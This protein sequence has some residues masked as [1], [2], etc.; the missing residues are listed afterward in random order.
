MDSLSGNAGRNH[1]S[2]IQLGQNLQR[3]GKDTETE[4]W[5]WAEQL[6][7]TATGSTLS[8]SLDRVSWQ[9]HTDRARTYTRAVPFYLACIKY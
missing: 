1:V 7:T 2:V 6:V 8:P 4:V 9:L 5:N 3:T